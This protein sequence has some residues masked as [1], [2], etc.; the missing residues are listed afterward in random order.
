MPA[1]L[2]AVA[3]AQPFL[4][5]RARGD[6]YRRLTRRC[7]PAAAVVAHSVLLPIRV[8]GVAGP[9][10]VGESQPRRAT[11]DD[12]AVRRPVALAERRDAVQQ[13]E[14]IARHWFRSL[15]TRLEFSIAVVANSLMPWRKTIPIS[16]KVPAG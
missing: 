5:D 11:V 9:E 7:A 10:S 13:A 12:T 1:H 14:G 16:S 4:R 15:N 2:N 6:A 8:I 3:L